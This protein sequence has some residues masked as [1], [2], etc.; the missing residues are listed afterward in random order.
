MPKSTE[1]SA[2]EHILLTA[3]APAQRAQFLP[4]IRSID[5]E[6]LI[7]GLLLLVAIAFNL[8]WLWPESAIRVPQLND[9]VLHQLLLG[10]T[11]AALASGESATDN[12][13]ATITLGYPLFHYYQHFAY[14]PPALFEYVS[15]FL[16]HVAL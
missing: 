16:L 1:L 4:F 6:T 12:W 3:N 13:L 8:Y 5:R 11:V 2:P 14:L 7:S 15:V 10:R 9:G